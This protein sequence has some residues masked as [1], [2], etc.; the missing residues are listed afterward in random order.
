MLVAYREKG[1]FVGSPLDAGEKLAQ[2]IRGGQ[3]ECLL[4]LRLLGAAHAGE[5][6]YFLSFYF[7]P[8]C[9]VSSEPNPSQATVL[10]TALQH[11]I[12]TEFGSAGNVGGSTFSEKRDGNQWR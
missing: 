3:F 5:R 11:S 6:H 8:W 2:F 9:H 7:F 1:V 10:H 12:L 4:W